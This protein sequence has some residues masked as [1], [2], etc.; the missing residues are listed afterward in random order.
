MDPAINDPLAKHMVVAAKAHNFGI[1]LEDS[2]RLAQRYPKSLPAQV[3]HAQLAL[4][5]H[6]YPESSA[7]FHKALSI[8]QDLVLAHLGLG[9][10][11]LS[12]KHF[13]IAMGSF[14]QVTRLAPSS[15]IGWVGLSV[16]AEKMGQ[17]KDSLTY[18]R[19]ATAVAPNSANVWVQA[20]HEES[21]AG[22]HQEAA[23]DLARA[24]KLRSHAAKPAKR[25]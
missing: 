20:A 21:L 24:N 25:A 15:Y 12:Q 14:Q 7:G 17:G 16:C 2:R 19:K 5:L 1:A 3:I 11:E 18:A 6:N 23:A 4:A 10:A 22:N 9:V 13:R 8:R